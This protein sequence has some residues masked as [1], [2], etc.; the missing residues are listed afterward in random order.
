MAIENEAAEEAR[1]M[2]RLV[3]IAGSSKEQIVANF[4]RD[5]LSLPGNGGS[6]ERDLAKQWFLRNGGNFQGDFERYAK[7]QS[8]FGDLDQSYPMED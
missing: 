6:D 8:F 2:A 3:Q 4:L 1:R 7:L 5:L